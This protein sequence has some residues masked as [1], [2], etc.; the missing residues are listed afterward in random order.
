MEK[1]E[2]KNFPELPVREM[3]YS[4]SVDELVKLI[5]HLKDEMKQCPSEDI[6]FNLIETVDYYG[7]TRNFKIKSKSDKSNNKTLDKFKENL[8]G[9]ISTYETF[10]VIPTVNSI[11]IETKSNK[12]NKFN[13]PKIY[14]INGDE[15]GP[16]LF[17]GQQ[18][19]LFLYD[20]LT[21]LTS[22]ITRNSN[23]NYLIY[24]VGVNM[25]FFDTKKTIK[26]NGLLNNN[27]FNFC[28][29]EIS[30]KSANSSGN[31]KITNLPRIAIIGADG[32]I[33]EDKCIK[34]VSFFEVQRDLIDNDGQKVVNM[35]EQTR[36]D[37]Y[38]FL[39]NDNKR[40]A[41]KSVN[42]YLKDN[43]LNN[44]HFY[45]K[46]KICI[47]KKGIKKTRCYPVFYGEAKT[48]EKNLIDNLIA[49]LNGQGLFYDIQCKVKYNQ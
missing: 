3:K 19:I 25:N 37:R 35:D 46:S 12:G 39:E 41:V 22:F 11:E 23:I 45:V 40:K 13:P 27:S 36:N 21:D 5:P 29:T 14:D 1:K 15:I 33:N 18:I 30:L 38:I 44:V 8:L 20:N 9:N 28:F 2:G 17:N 16:Q 32:I 47:D 48:N 10:L 7:L 34:N 26:N 4:Q 43:Q 24:C 31:L 6:I 49:S 42:I